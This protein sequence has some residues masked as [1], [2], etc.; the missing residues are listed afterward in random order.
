MIFEK[1]IIGAYKSVFDKRTDDTGAVHYFT[2]LDFEGLCTCPYGFLGAHG[3]KLVG[4]FY[5]YGEFTSDRIIIFEHGMGGGHL[6]YMKEIELLCRHGYTVLSYDHTGCMKS[7]GD[8]TGGFAES[9]SNLD[10]LIKSL[11]ASDSFKNASLSVIG[12]SWGGFSTLNISGIHKDITHV[13]ALAGFISVK[14]V[15]NQFFSGPLRLYVPKIM[16]IERERNPQFCDTD[17]VLS[18][19]SSNTKALIIQSRDDKTVS[20]KKNFAVLEE[21]L[22]DR[23]DTHFIALDGHG[24]N[25]NYTPDAVKYKDEFFKKLTEFLK[26][27]GAADQQAQRTFKESFDFERMTAQDKDLWNIIFDFLDN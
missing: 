18:L 22:R 21:A 3:Q 24:H 16:R 26:S 11:K 4:A 23:P 14:T 2:H 17:A 8:G 20:Y 9:L 6:S 25:P 12:H 5:Y 7:E 15:L 10:S 13:V 27:P 1:K 19:K